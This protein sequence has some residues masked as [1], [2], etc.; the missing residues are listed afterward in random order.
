MLVF[1]GFVF[2]EEKA[3]PP[4]EPLAPCLEDSFFF[5]TNASPPLVLLV[6]NEAT[7][8]SPPKELLACVD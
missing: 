3:P 7:S 1:D 4:F 2:F 8:E 5:A 6:P